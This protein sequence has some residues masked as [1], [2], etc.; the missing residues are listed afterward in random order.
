MM[1][2]FFIYLGYEILDFYLVLKVNFI[3]K[4]LSYLIPNEFFYVR[5]EFS[6]SIQHGKGIIVTMVL[7]I[8]GF[9]KK[10]I[11]LKVWIVDLFNVFRV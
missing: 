2:K 5:N 11:S 6:Q 3:E 9:V 1:N 8:L 10:G 4:L 7:I